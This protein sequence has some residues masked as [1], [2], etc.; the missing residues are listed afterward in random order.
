MS[1]SALTTFGL[2]P[3]NS[4]F[5][6]GSPNVLQTDSLPGKT[7]IGPTINSGSFSGEAPYV[8]PFYAVFWHCAVVV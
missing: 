5:A 4:S 1:G 3:R 8:L 6:S 7:R 2:P